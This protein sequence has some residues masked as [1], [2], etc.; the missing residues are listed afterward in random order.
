MRPAIGV[1]SNFGI[2]TESGPPREQSYLLGRYTDAV[3]A[4]GGMPHPVPVPPNHD[5]HLID[6]LLAGYAG[7]VFT[8]GYDLH[9]RHYSEQA[10]ERTHPLHERRDS[11]EMDLFR[12]ADARKIPIF[13]ICL[14]FQIAH[15]ARGGRLIQHVDDIPGRTP[16]VV[17]YRPRDANAFHR[18]RIEPDS[19]LA[20]IVGSN[21]VECASRHHQVID[22]LHQGAG[23]RPVGY[24]P[25]GILEASEDCDG[26]FLIGVQWHPEEQFDRPEQHRLF[27]ALVKAASERNF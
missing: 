8:G 4:A 16:P 26:R 7:L 14:G 25:D 9:P 24:A 23:L 18:V 11:F 6:E 27:A 2:D 20:T 12:R 5:D 1:T 22:V 19:S 10:H 17:H 13:A 3:F 15:V 21:D